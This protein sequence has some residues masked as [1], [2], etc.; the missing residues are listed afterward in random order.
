MA[1]TKIFVNLPVK[2][3]KKSMSFWKA[4]GYSFNAQFSDDTAACLVF[5]DDIYAMLL[6]HEKFKSFAPNPIS[7]A[8]KSNEVLLCLGCD[9]KDE[10]SDKV[11]RALDAGGKRFS[12]PKDHGFMIQ[13]A[14]QDPDGHVWELVYMDPSFVQK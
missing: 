9:S 12:E 4:L 1:T 13:D 8:H 14:F 3:L 2:D 6:T 5:S 7:D 11:R 10:V